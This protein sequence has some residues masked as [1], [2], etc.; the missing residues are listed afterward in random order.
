MWWVILC[1]GILLVLPAVLSGNEEYEKRKEIIKTTEANQEKYIQEK[2]ISKSADFEWHDSM[3]RYRYRFI[4]DDIAQKV[5]VSAGIDVSE[6]DEIPYEEII[7]FEVIED[8]QVVGGIKRAI[9]GGVLAGAAGAIVGSQTANKTAVSSM[10]AVISRKNVNSPQYTLEFIKTKTKTSSSAYSSAKIFT[11]NINA[12]LKAVM[13]KA[14]CT[15]KPAQ[16]STSTST[17]ET[18]NNDEIME[19]LKILKNAYDDNLVTETEYEE[20]KKELLS[21]L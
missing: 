17:S 8:S 9:V 1:I 5:Y 3:N 4:A 2:G 21:R 12:T 18:Q 7:G 16:K 11:D 10:K 15:T 14:D 19:R 13:A 6:L 20:K